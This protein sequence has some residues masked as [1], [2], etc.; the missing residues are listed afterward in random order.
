MSKDKFPNWTQNAV[1]KIV[2]VCHELADDGDVPLHFDIEEA[3]R[4]AWE[5]RDKE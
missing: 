2:R 1:K 3:M 4:D 5:E